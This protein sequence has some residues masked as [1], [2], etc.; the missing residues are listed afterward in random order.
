M[1]P[2]TFVKDKP[3]D[4]VDDVFHDMVKKAAEQFY[5]AMIT[6]AGDADQEAAGQARFETAL[7]TFKRA[8]AMSLDSARKILG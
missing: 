8:H 5:D 1:T 4:A 6:A 2:S 3:A 7:T